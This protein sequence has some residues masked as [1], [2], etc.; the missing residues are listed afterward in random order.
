MSQLP[1]KKFEAYRDRFN[2]ATMC[3]RVLTRDEVYAA[4]IEGMDAVD[5]AATNDRLAKEYD[6]SIEDE[7]ETYHR[8][9]TRGHRI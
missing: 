6:G 7:L 1:S 9:R 8:L 2:N 4:F 3:R 5:L